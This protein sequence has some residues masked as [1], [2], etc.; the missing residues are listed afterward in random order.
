MTCKRQRDV[1]DLVEEQGP[2]FGKLDLA[3]VGL[4]RAGEGAALVAEQL[5]FE[6]VLR[7]GGAVD[8]D[9]AALAPAL[10][11][12]GAGEQLLA[13][14]ARAEKHYRHVRARHALDG[15]CDLQHLRGG[16]D[17]RAE[18]R[19]AAVARLQPAILL[20]DRVQVEGPRDDEAEVVDVDRL[21]VEI[22][23]AEGDCLESA[24]AGAVTGRDDDLGVGLEPHDFLEGCKALL[25]PVW[26]RRKAEVERDD[27]RLMRAQSLDRARPVAR[28]D[29][30]VAV[31]GPFE[32]PLQA[33]VVLHDEQDGEVGGFGHALIRSWS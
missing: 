1:A 4:D 18:H 3:D 12:D 26:V 32:L 30:A 29:H 10:L 24:L 13:G 5:G 8:G 17:D 2:A 31:V 20:L 9:E 11:V 23:G 19:R 14:A 21:L 16:R 33:L 27:G 22:V 25:G 28:A 15:L 6:Q 7:D